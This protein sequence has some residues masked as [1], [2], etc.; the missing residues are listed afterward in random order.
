MSET[1]DVS[2]GA[3][4]SISEEMA[5]LKRRFSHNHAMAIHLNLLA[6]IGT[7]IYGVRLGARIA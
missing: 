2:S 5:L 7:A 1:R 4:D 6:I 3:D